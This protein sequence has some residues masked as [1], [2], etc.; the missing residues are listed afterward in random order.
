MDAYSLSH[1]LLDAW[2]TVMIG[3]QDATSINKK[4][5]EIHAVVVL[6]DEGRR[7][8]I[9]CRIEGNYIVLDLEG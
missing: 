1:K 3:S 2:R 8:V 6:D 9:G 4:Y 7:K 5:P